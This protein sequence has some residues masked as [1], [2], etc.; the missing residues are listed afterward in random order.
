MNN[1]DI[2]FEIQKILDE[3]KDTEVLFK[4]LES[5]L[6]KSHIDNSFEDREKAL[7]LLKD[8]I[9][10]A[11]QDGSLRALSYQDEKDNSKKTTSIRRGNVYFV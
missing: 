6:Q 8:A 3:F 11:E 9:K 10:K 2:D 1:I 7:A 5:I 4:E